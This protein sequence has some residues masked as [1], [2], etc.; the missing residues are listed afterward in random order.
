MCAGRQPVRVVR[1]AGGDVRRGCTASVLLVDLI[2]QTGIC[3]ARRPVQAQFLQS[4]CI[5]RGIGT[6]RPVS[7]PPPASLMSPCPH[8]RRDRT[9][10][11]S[12]CSRPW[13]AG[14]S[15]SS[16]RR[17]TAHGLTSIVTLDL[18]SYSPGLGLSPLGD[19]TAICENE[20][21]PRVVMTRMP[22]KIINPAHLVWRKLYFLRLSNLIKHAIPRVSQNWT[23][24]VRS[25][26]KQSAITARTKSAFRVPLP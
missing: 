15:S 22:G 26:A 9:G 7:S 10:R 13:K 6:C 3:P 19:M 5:G 25:A 2:G 8:G 24:C 14:T 16:A 1:P 21:K 20:L 11:F 23:L 4:S 17:R 12:R 18:C